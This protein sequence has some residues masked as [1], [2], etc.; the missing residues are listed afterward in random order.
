MQVK[1]KHHARKHR[2][3]YTISAVLLIFII[4]ALAG[5][6]RAILSTRKSFYTAAL[7]RQS[8]S[9]LSLYH[10]SSSTL[11]HQYF[12]E[13]IDTVNNLATNTAIQQQLT[14]NQQAT[15][16]ASL[17]QQRTISGQFDSLTMLSAKGAVAAFSSNKGTLPV[18]ADGSQS[19]GYIA[20]K[21]ASGAVLVDAHLGPLNRI[22]L[23]V[24][25]PVKDKKNTFLG[26]AIGALTIDTLADNIQLSSQYNTNLTSLLT[27]SQGNALVWQ[28]HSAQA[29]LNLKDKEPSLGALM[30]QQTVPANEEYNFERKN[31]LAQGS[32]I[33]FGTA[34]KLYVVS[35]YDVNGYK[36]YLNDAIQNINATFSGFILRNSLLFIGS[37]VVIGLVIRAYDETRDA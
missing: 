5:N 27:D 19:P 9:E 11:V 35:F 16:A 20:A 30:H 8:L 36:T 4:A 23:T 1:I 13:A 14:G 12:K 28:N 2:L 29:L 15:L 25:S 34:G 10:E 17:E 18:G 3:L 24:A 6:Y 26:V 33:D 31:S 7:E 21:A 32:T 37:V 22:V